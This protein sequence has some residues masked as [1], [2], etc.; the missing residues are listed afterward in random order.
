[1]WLQITYKLVVPQ[2][3]TWN[4]STTVDAAQ[5]TLTLCQLQS[6]T[7][8]LI[9]VSA[10]TTTTTRG[11]QVLGSPHVARF[12]TTLAERPSRPLVVSTSPTS[13]SLSVQPVDNSVVDDDVVTTVTYTVMYGRNN[14]GS[15]G[16]PMVQQGQWI[17][18][19]D[20]WHIGLQLTAQQMSQQK[21][22]V[23]GDPVRTMS[24]QLIP[25]T[26]YS[27]SLVALALMVDRHV[28]FTYSWPPVSLTTLP[29]TTSTQSTS[30]HHSTS[31]YLDSSTTAGDAKEFDVTSATVTHPHA[32]SADV[33]L[34]NE[35]SLTT[36]KP[37]A[38][39]SSSSALTT[40]TIRSF[41]SFLATAV[42]ARTATTTEK[43]LSSS[44]SSSSYF[45]LSSSSAAAPTARVQAEVKPASRQATTTVTTSSRD[46][47]TVLSTRLDQSSKFRRLTVT[48]V[49]EHVTSSSAV[50]TSKTSPA[51][52]QTLTTDLLTP[53]QATTDSVIVTTQPVTVG[54]YVM[55]IR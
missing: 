14:G 20:G 37:P 17:F 15:L 23:L 36:A 18:V 52:L 46:W 9:S 13:A 30:D 55:C 47:T 33:S 21:T 43:P 12:W 1:M 48:A 3:S 51:P 27:V 2:N 29:L 35:T 7:K 50:A 45:S 34:V 6:L 5:T 53:R 16:P 32:S 39:T 25:E 49:V 28:T 54:T 44:L 42:D 22:V 4:G 10:V 41:A 19:G 38:S 26:N 24:P 31:A 40:S 11:P 8:Y